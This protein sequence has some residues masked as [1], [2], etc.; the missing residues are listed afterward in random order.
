MRL[1][2]RYSKQI[3]CALVSSFAL[4]LFFLS[5]P[6]YAREN[7]TLIYQNDIHGWLFPSSVRTGMVEMERLLARLFEDEPNSFFAVSGDLFTGPDFPAG[8]RGSMERSIWN[9][10]HE[11]LAAKGF[12]D[13]VLLSAGNHEFDYGVPAPGSFSSRLLC[14]NVVNKDG[15]P[16]FTPYK[17]I[18]TKKDFTAGFV[19]LLLEGSGAVV[20]LLK[21]EG[22]EIISMKSAVERFVP[23]M[24]HPDL[25]VL[26]VHAGLPEIVKMLRSLPDDLG[27]DVVL[28]GHDHLVL[29]EPLCI[30]GVYVFQSGAINHAYGRAELVL[31]SGRVLEIRNRI[32]EMKPSPLAHAVMRAKEEVD[33][34]RG[35]MLAKV[36]NPLLGVSLRN[37]ENGLGDLVTDAFRWAT[38][39]DVAMTNSSSLRTD[40]LVYPGTTRE[41]F[42]GDIRVL[43]PYGNRLV[44]G[45][46]T[47]EKMMKILEGEAE[48]FRNQVS[49][50]HYRVDLGRP[51]GK[52]VVQAVVG[53]KPLSAARVYT[54][55]HNSYCTRPE[56]MEKYLHV[57][58]GSIQWKSTGLVDRDAVKRYVEH[59]EIVDYETDGSGRIELV[60]RRTLKENL[61]VPRP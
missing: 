43:C 49:G 10:F 50:M 44:V 22:L 8:M 9:R 58:P 14:A 5:S 32:V 56:N 19:G 12:G 23:E 52:R 39:A 28:S 7:V 41:L 48:S 33:A 46:V 38:G 60:G 34:R 40:F 21:R 59:L 31:D 30:Q 25:T 17:L 3:L 57:E 45:E 42:E 20:R 55:A 16:Y 61:E 18:R 15:S 54:L 1:A 11:S 37:R 2:G 4:V 29:E 24:G 47:G 36:R 51:V 13:R 6:G 27:V 53:G 35:K 26:M